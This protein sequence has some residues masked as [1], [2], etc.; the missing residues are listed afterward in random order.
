MN[1]AEQQKCDDRGITNGETPNP[2]PVPQCKGCLKVTDEPHECT[3]CGNDHCYKC[4]NINY[5]GVGLDFC[6]K[7]QD[8]PDLIIKTLI[9]ALVL[10]KSEGK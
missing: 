3:I 10:L 7:C 1:P 6:K 8:D 5:L 2:D 4:I 9:D